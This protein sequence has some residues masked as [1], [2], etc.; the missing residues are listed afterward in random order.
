MSKTILITGCTSG[1][2]Y[3][4]AL[5]FANNG[6]KV[7]AVGRDKKLLDELSTKSDL[8][9]PFETDIT[10]KNRGDIIL[11]ALQYEESISI[12]HNAGIAKPSLISELTEDL[13]K[14]HF[15][16][17][18][19]APILLS[20][21]LLPLLN[22]DSRVLYISSGA[23]DLALQGLM[24]YCTSKA[25]FER[26]THCFNQEFNPK[27][28]YFGN[29]RPGM[30]DTN[31]QKKL[32]EENVANLPTRDFYLSAKNNHNLIP[33]QLAAEF[34]FWVMTQTTNMN[35]GETLWNIS[36][37]KYRDAWYPK[38]LTNNWTL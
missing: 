29:L 37:T 4:L 18:F 5:R 38:T 9:I 31:M 14:K 22:Q 25:A 2:G 33:P 21:H 12:I 8:I 28:I 11:K 30:V 1:I 26:A 10:D 13:L 16:T 34:I 17:N 27:G 3:A 23:G 15:E 19:Y 24:P 20:Q 32:R 36:D 7:Y 6:Y 35:F